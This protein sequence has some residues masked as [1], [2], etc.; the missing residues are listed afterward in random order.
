MLYIRREIYESTESHLVPTF[1]IISR[2]GIKS[3][4]NEVFQ[5]VLLLKNFDLRICFAA[6]KTDHSVQG[7]SLQ[8][9]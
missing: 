7:G 4:L 3:G 5:I 2:Q 1:Q 9:V 6:V 8:S